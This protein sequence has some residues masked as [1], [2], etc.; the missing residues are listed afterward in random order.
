MTTV[1]KELL[2][3][4]EFAYTEQEKLFD[5]NLNRMAQL[6]EQIQ[7]LKENN[8]TITNGMKLLSKK[9]KELQS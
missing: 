4:L 7:A 1:T 3:A 9:I 8:V 2:E 6:Q 5:D